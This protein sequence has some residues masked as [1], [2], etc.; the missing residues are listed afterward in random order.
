MIEKEETDKAFIDE[1]YEKIEAKQVVQVRK[2]LV[3]N[4][5]KFNGEY[6]S[7]LK[8]LFNYTFEKEDLKEIFK[9]ELLIIISEYLYR[10]TFV[11]DKEINAFTCCL[12]LVKKL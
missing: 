9:R 1:L 11:L 4:D 7:L 5:D 8:L 10:N 12:E 3:E 2:F 6:H